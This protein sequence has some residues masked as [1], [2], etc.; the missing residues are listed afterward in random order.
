VLP[1]ALVSLGLAAV[2]RIAAAAVALGISA[3]AVTLA[4]LG[5][6]AVACV[7]LA[8]GHYAWAWLALTVASVGD[9]VDGAVARKSASASLPGALLD[10]SVDRYE[11][12]LLLGGLAI[13]LR[14]SVPALVLCVAALTGAFMVSYG[15]A[16]AEAIGAPVPPGAMRR[17][18]RAL[19]L[20][21]GVGL[22]ALMMPLAAAGSLPPSVVRIPL[23][24]ALGL[25]AVVGNVS[26]V[27]RLVALGALARA[28][29][30]TPAL[31]VQVVS[32]RRADAAGESAAPA[33]SGPS[34][35][36]VP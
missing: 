7:L 33:S 4:S 36:P 28:R 3:N 23:L 25:V 10:A 30:S 5:L 35:L 13:H 16:K 32:S 22:S 6:S 1:R 19:S 8:L 11:E 15:S 29:C 34:I 17:A 20:S 14:Q 9:A 24:V 12:A 26:A 18:E 27:R 2:D 21:A 31:A